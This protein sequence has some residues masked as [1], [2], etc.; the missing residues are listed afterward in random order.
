MTYGIV[1]ALTDVRVERLYVHVLDHGTVRGLIVKSKSLA[2]TSI[3]CITWI[4]YSCQRVTI[5]VTPDPYVCFEKL[6]PLAFP[7]DGVHVTTGLYTFD[8]TFRFP[9]QVTHGLD[10]HGVEGLLIITRW[11]TVVQTAKEGTE[12]FMMSRL[13]IC[14]C[15]QFDIHQIDLI[16]RPCVLVSDTGD[17]FAVRDPSHRLVSVVSHTSVTIGWNPCNG[18]FF[19][20]RSAKHVHSSTYN[21][22]TAQGINSALSE[23]RNPKLHAARQTKQRQP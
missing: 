21:C 6:I 5:H 14:V 12:P 4:Q 23:K 11:A 16:P 18:I 15:L 22:T 3:Q 7:H 20:V 2:T 19:Q 13:I 17:L 1:F 9:I 10:D 8:S